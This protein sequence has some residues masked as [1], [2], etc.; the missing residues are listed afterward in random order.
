MGLHNRHSCVVVAAG[1]T[2]LRTPYS[3]GLFCTFITL[4]PISSFYCHFDTGYLNRF[5]DTFEGSGIP[6]V[7]FDV[8]CSYDEGRGL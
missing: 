2:H 6:R 3:Q 5:L 7:L 1:L 4:T 8:K